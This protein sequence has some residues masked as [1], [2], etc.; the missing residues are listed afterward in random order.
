MRNRAIDIA[1]ETAEGFSLPPFGIPLHDLRQLVLTS[2]GRR[3]HARQFQERFDEDVF[4]H[5]SSAHLA[6]G[7]HSGDPVL[8][9]NTAKNLIARGVRLGAHPSYPDAFNFGQE[10][11]DL[12][13]DELEAVLLY[14]FG[15]LDSVVSGVGGRLDHV[16]C[17]GAL[18]FD[19]AYDE[20]YCQAMIDAVNKFDP[21]L[22]VVFMAES[23]GLQ[24][25]KSKGVR[26]AAE[27]YADRGYARDGRLVARDHP[28]ALL[29]TPEQAANRILEIVREGKVTCVDGTRIEMSVDTVCLH[30]DTAGAGAIAAAVREALDRCRVEVRPLREVVG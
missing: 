13:T 14:Q 24:Y 21:E 19:I 17:H 15:A 18:A 25:A 11:L 20:R 8:I 1:T 28:Q 12:S 4:P 2:S 16:K 6:C 7:V 29:K 26:V 9:R 23:P 5:I 30:S 27:G 22:I 3:L 10:R